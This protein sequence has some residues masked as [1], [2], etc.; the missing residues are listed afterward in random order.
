MGQVASAL[1]PRAEK[2]GVTFQR[3]ENIKICMFEGLP[4]K[5]ST[6]LL[7]LHVRTIQLY[8]SLSSEI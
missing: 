1:A 2:V 4:T 7:L 6:T 5:V 3:T 8:L